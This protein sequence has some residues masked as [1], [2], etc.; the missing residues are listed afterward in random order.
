MHQNVTFS[1]SAEISEHVKQAEYGAH[2]LLIY[3]GLSTLREIYLRCIKSEIE[4]NNNI[5]L[6]LSYYESPDMLRKI[7]YDGMKLKGFCIYHKAD[8]DRRLAEEQKQKL[9]NHHGKGLLIDPSH[10]FQ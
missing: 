6:I 4:Y 3:P 10:M 1:S 2:Y 7:L 5:V 9:L 8:F